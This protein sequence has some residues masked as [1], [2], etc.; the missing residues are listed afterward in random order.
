MLALVSLPQPG[1]PIQLAAA[2]MMTDDPT[3]A[4]STDHMLRRTKE[5]AQPDMPAKMFRP[6]EVELSPE[7][8]AT[9]EM[10]ENEG[11]IDWL[12][13]RVGTAAQVLPWLPPVECVLAPG[14]CRLA[15]VGDCL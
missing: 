10:A 3:K 4:V 11:V 2:Q 9:Y 1:L 12:L 6:A 5:M 8:R 14:V 13:R 7:Q 15:D